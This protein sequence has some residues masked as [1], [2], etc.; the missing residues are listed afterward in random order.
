M[1]SARHAGW[2]SSRRPWPD[3]RPAGDSARS[4]SRRPPNQGGSRR[5]PK[6]HFPAKA[7]RYHR[8]DEDSQRLAHRPQ[9]V[10]AEGRA[11][12]SRRGPA[13]YER[14]ADR[15]GRPGHAD[16][17]RRAEQRAIAAGQRNNEGGQR[18]EREQR[19]EDEAS[20]ESIRQH[21]HRQP[22]QRAE[23][24][25]HCDQERGLR[26]GQSVQASEDRRESANKAPRGERECERDRRKDQRARR[27]RGRTVT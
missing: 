5:C 6:H 2:P 14:R 16:Q 22:C 8:A 23:Q 26:C 27:R 17:E 13:G 19:R 7:G 4:G 24:H 1:R 3:D 20:A 11:L 25:R 9:A 10:D 21:A 15:E 12:P 18:R